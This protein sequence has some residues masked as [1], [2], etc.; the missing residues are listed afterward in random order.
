VKPR[1][2]ANHVNIAWFFNTTSASL[3]HLGHYPITAVYL[4]LS[5]AS[6]GFCLEAEEDEVVLTACVADLP[7]QKWTIDPV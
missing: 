4:L 6:G 5:L 3:Q 2:C 1:K 7:S